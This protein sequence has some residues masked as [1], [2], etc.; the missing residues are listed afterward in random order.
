M[1]IV[2]IGGTDHETIGDVSFTLNAED[3]LDQCAFAIAPYSYYNNGKYAG[4]KWEPIRFSDGDVMREFSLYQYA[5]YASLE[6][7]T[8]QGVEPTRILDELSL[9]GFALSP[10]TSGG[11]AKLNA[12]MT[13]VELVRKL[14][15]RLTA[16]GS[17][18]SLAIPSSLTEGSNPF[19][20]EPGEVIADGVRTFREIIDYWLSSFD[21]AIR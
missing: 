2:N 13:F 3:A 20:K 17:S 12:W 14:N 10:I 21:L 9:K 6:R 7:T 11:T 1:M 18:Y 8:I 5:Y 16:M 4:T 15:Q 19:S